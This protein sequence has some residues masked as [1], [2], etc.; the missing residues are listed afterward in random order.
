MAGFTL[1]DFYSDEILVLDTETTGLKGAP[2][3][4]VVDIGITKVSLSKGTV[5]ELY[6]SIVGYDVDEWNDYRRNAWIFENT[7]LTLDMVA[8]APPLIHVMDSVRRIL[9]GK[10]VTSYNVAYD[11]D[12][13]LYREPWSLKGTF[14]QCKDIMIAAT[15]VCKFPSEYYGRQ[16]RYPKLDAAYAKILDDRDP[17]GIAGDQK[18][19]ALS[20]AVMASYIMIEMWRNGEYNPGTGCR[21]RSDHR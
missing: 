17:A 11:F 19:R 12:K 16:Y 1:D 7:D 8:E 21:S 10:W 15:E 2:D 5:K 9:K 4:V 20:D 3:D 18:H 6:S 14:Y 13:F